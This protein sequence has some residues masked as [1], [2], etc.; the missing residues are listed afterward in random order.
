[1]KVTEERRRVT[2]D[3]RRTELKVMVFGQGSRYSVMIM[4]DDRQPELKVMVDPLIP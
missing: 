2:T 3:N 1:M 4:T